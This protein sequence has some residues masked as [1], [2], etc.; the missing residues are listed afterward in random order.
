MK[1]QQINTFYGGMQ[2]D[3]ANTAPQ[4]GM[5]TYAGNVRIVAGENGGA[6]S[7]IIT[8]IKDTKTQ[9]TLNHTV[10]T[11][12]WL[13][14]ANG[15]NRPVRTELGEAPCEIKG[16][17]TIRNTLILFCYVP[18]KLFGFVGSSSTSC[19]YSVDL[20]TFNAATLIYDD[21]DLNFY[22]SDNI[23]AVGRY[24]S[25]D[26]QRVYWTDGV[27]PIRTINIKN[28][29]ASSLSVD[30]LVLNPPIN[31]GAPKVTEVTNNGALPAGMYQYCYRLKSADGK[32]TRFSPLS[33]FVHVVR[34]S[35]YWEYEPD[36]E[37]QTEYSNTPVGEVTDKSVTLKISNVN[38][39][40]DTIEIVS[41][42]KTNPE[43]PESVTIIDTLN[44]SSET[45][46]AR[47][48]DNNGT[49]LLLEEITAITS[50]PS[51]AKVLT[52]KDNRLFLGGI[53]YNT[54]SLDFDARAFRYK[55]NDNELYPRTGVTEANTSTYV[56]VDFDI[57]TLEGE[58]TYTAQENL[59]AVNPFNT[60]GKENNPEFSY[61]FQP[62]GVTLGGKGRNVQ[63][64]FFKKRLDGNTL[65]EI[66]EASPFIK[67]NIKTNTGLNEPYRPS[68]F[69]NGDYKSPSNATEFVGYRRDE[70]YRFGV[71]LYDL[72]GNPGFVN[73]IG[74]IKFPD[75][76]DY[77]HDEYAPIRNFTLAQQYKPNSVSDHTM[78][79]NYFWDYNNTVDAYEHSN[80]AHN[81]GSFQADATY[82][83]YN[84][85]LPDSTDSHLFA[86]G[87][88]VV[89][90]IPE[91]LQDKISGYRVVRV[92][93]DLSNKTVLGSGIINYLHKFE[94]PDR[95][96]ETFAAFG[97]HE[98]T[99]SYSL[100]NSKDYP[101]GYNSEGGNRKVRGEFMS[102]VFSIDSPEWPFE[103]YPSFD[104]NTYLKVDGAVRGVRKF[105]FTED[106]SGNSF[107]G[108]ATIFCQHA[109]PPIKDNLGAVHEIEYLGKLDQ[110][111]IG[112]EIEGIDNELG[113]FNRTSF[114][115]NN[116][117]RVWGGVGEETLLCKTGSDVDWNNYLSNYDA[118]GGT[119]KVM[120]TVKKDL[121]DSQ[122]GGN[123]QL[124]RASNSYIPAGPFISMEN[125]VYIDP[126]YNRHEV[127]GGD[128]YVVMYDIEKVRKFNESLS[129]HSG[130]PARDS[131]KFNKESISFAFP[132][133]SSV[134]TTLRSGW[135]FANKEDWDDDTETPL[136]TF[137]L[138]NV[139]SSV[140]S[141]EIYIS[142][143]D[144]FQGVSE[145]DSRV[146]YSDSKENNTPQ[147]SWLSYRVENYKDLDGNR[148]ALNAL[149]NFK[150]TLY[151]FQENG[152]GALAVNPT[153]TVLDQS[154]VSI[155]LGTGDVIQDFKYLSN[156]AGV[157]SSKSITTSEGA[158]Y[159]ADVNLK[160][161]YSLSEK[162]MQSITDSYGMKAWAHEHITS[163]YTPRLGYDEKFNEIYIVYD[164]L[165]N[166]TLIFN[167]AIQRF[168][169]FYSIHSADIFIQALNNTYITSS[170]DNTRGIVY[171]INEGSY[172]SSSIEFTV[173]KNP[174]NVKVFD[175]LEWYSDN[176]F[177]DN[178][179]IASY[180]TSGQIA[181]T[182][183]T[184]GEES[185][186]YLDLVKKENT[187]KLKI[188]RELGTKNR[189]R[190]NYLKIHMTFEAS[191]KLVLHYVKTLFR[192]S[193]R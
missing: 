47:H 180:T 123:T 90:N 138:D 53:S 44:V 84:S 103:G 50:S 66:P 120:V 101:A 184:V 193:R 94:D 107:D 164:S 190:D 178:L 24:E 7:G 98:A 81:A 65:R 128:T 126:E 38:P 124:N 68:Y 72:Q 167:E 112:K 91:G 26:L 85:S 67:S 151:F 109:L 39:D 12:A 22:V 181:T 111:E 61:K 56:D 188:P 20:D 89:V 105:N 1:D 42:Y 182:L 79:V 140:N 18:A 87:L 70:V 82:D 149:I 4:E 187:I 153:S 16:Y 6:S 143:P 73:W 99:T 159:F 139:Y 175:T 157:K 150:D 57:L 160:K 121:G 86:L 158:I 130:Q 192:I 96:N 2:K 27:N 48:T 155:V 152:F 83:R 100:S 71:V 25:E 30:D 45:I 43:T 147:D 133:E 171:A 117:Y 33:N 102:N 156:K 3:L 144:N 9:L 8:N 52:A 69:E 54:T 119:G 74:D 136:N 104:S 135:H 114:I 106:T 36:P 176:K 185:E 183:S 125:S 58:G 64:R 75:H 77:D 14:D 177:A 154:G 46:T 80:E 172:L 59:D 129:S 131:D 170:L 15:I 93:R 134:N 137:E 32:A 162:G 11:T 142:K 28:K 40:Y 191:K 161:I 62:D 189:L 41:I 76:H 95:D 21:P 49:P 179:T 118:R 168:T 78:G 174:F 173:N 108:S 88:E 163:D 63:Y 145:Y 23:S 148:G 10:Y 146:V 165:K 122:Y 60:Q 35:D 132:A 110:A 169:S 97:S 19:I 141:T 51:K 55:R 5:Y 115:H 34:G 37:A 13:P 29:N 92:E 31:F 113:V 116:D 127:W 166:R 186:G 17:T